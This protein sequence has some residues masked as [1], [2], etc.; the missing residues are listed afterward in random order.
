MDD[1]Q[2]KRFLI[3]LLRVAIRELL[4]YRTFCEKAKSDLGSPGN[5]EI[6]GFL[7]LVRNDTHVATQLGPD[8]VT[9]VEEILQGPER[10]AGQ[11]LD[12]FLRG[13]TPRSSA[14]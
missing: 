10:D 11:A 9:F 12:A 7:N 4:V 2:Q 14:N 13:W 8:F 1:N 6:D 5:R 3:D